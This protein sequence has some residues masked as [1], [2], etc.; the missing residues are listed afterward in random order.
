MKVKLVIFGEPKCKQ[1]AR[2]FNKKGSIH[3]YQP[4]KV[5]RDTNNIQIQVIS[6]LP[7]NFK[8][9]NGPI[10]VH[11]ALFVFAPLKNLSKRKLNAIEKEQVYKS[12]KPDLHDNLFKNL[13]DS[14]EGIVYLNDSQIVEVRNASKIYGIEPRTELILEEIEKPN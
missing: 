1:S 9:M 2:F 10:I 12:T 5:K 4:E 7:F 11:Q 13:M 3:S 8:P 14:L 6:Q